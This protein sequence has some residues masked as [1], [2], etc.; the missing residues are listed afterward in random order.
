MAVIVLVVLL[1]GGG[2]GAFLLL[3]RPGDGMNGADD[4]T[5]CG[6]GGGW[7]PPGTPFAA[8]ICWR[9]F[10]AIASVGLSATTCLSWASAASLW[11][12]VR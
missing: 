4:P 2:V 6:V 11:P 7:S 12:S 1:A 5:G 3:H 9:S 8:Y 10:V